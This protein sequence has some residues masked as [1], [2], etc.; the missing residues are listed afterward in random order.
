M[1]MTSKLPYWERDN[2]GRCDSPHPGEEPVDA[3]D[4]DW[5]PAESGPTP[6]DVRDAFDRN[7]EMAEPEPEYGDFWPELDDATDAY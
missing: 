5:G 1:K 2:P 7:D 4:D 3:Q 6:V